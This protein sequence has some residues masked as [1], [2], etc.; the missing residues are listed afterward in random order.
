MRHIPLSGRAIRAGLVTSLTLLA[1]FA[2]TSPAMADEGITAATTAASQLECQDPVLSQPFSGLKDYRDYVLAPGGDFSDPD[3]AGWQLFGGARV[4]DVVT[5][6]GT[7]GGSL[8]MPSGSTAVSPVMCVD[9]TYP[10]ARLW[11]QKLGGDGD[12][13]FSV[14]YAGT[15]TELKPKAVGHFRGDHRRW[16]LSGDIHIKPDLAG[17]A[18]GWRMVAFVL[19]AG[20][21]NGEF[22]MD[23]LYVD[24]RMSR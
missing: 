18:D 13:Q 15:K 16:K 11:A 19:I 5:P 12:V 9:T 10:T 20:G 8:Y 4:V 22:Q 23:D 17:K 24:P 2:S 7:A 21:K 1:A 3:G 6:D 14:A